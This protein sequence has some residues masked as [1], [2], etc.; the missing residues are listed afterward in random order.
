MII[1]ALLLTVVLQTTTGQAAVAA[2]NPSNCNRDATILYA[3]QPEIPK[4]TPKV[5]ANVTV[6]VDIAPTGTVTSVSIVKSSGV[7][8]IDLATAEAARASKYKPAMSNCKAVQGSYLFH[9][10][11]SP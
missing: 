6:R 7:S 2:A 8:A 4:S 5:T 11:V 10:A 3:A 9:V 1:L